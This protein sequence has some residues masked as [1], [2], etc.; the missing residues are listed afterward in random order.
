MAELTMKAVACH[1]LILGPDF[2]QLLRH[3]MSATPDLTSSLGLTS[4]RR[5][6]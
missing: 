1:G 3:A 2:E 6:R 5:T 4:P